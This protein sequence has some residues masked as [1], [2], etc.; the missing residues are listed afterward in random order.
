MYVSRPLNWIPPI[1]A[2]KSTK[3]LKQLSLYFVLTIISNLFA[4]GQRS[5]TYVDHSTGF[6]LIFAEKSRNSVSKIF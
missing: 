2:E 5:I 1:F 4:T 3:F 6:S